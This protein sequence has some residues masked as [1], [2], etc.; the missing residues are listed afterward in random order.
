MSTYFGSQISPNKVETAEG[1]LICRNVPIARIGFQ[2]YLAHE[3]QLDGD[4]DR[5]VKVNRYEEDVFDKAAVASFEGK[6]VRDTHPNEAVGPENYSK[7]A[8]GHAQNVRREGDFIKGL[9]HV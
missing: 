5:L 9:T 3:L 8:K 2:D 7:L 6:P 4:P 1:F